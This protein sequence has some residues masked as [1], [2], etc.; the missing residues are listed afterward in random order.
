VRPLYALH[1]AKVAARSQWVERMLKTVRHNL[2]DRSDMPRDIQW[3]TNTN[4]TDPD[5][6]IKDFQPSGIWTG[7]TVAGSG[8]GPELESGPRTGRVHP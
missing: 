3:P 6:P 1:M 8:S 5:E 2:K 7:R 4:R